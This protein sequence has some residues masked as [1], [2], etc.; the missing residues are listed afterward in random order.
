[1]GPQARS[2][3]G[4]FVRSGN[5]LSPQPLSTGRAVAAQQ[6]STVTHFNEDNRQCGLVRAGATIGLDPQRYVNER[7]SPRHGQGGPT[8]SPSQGIQ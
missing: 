5:V 1:M 2:S 6:R 8:A 7:L 3:V 4:A